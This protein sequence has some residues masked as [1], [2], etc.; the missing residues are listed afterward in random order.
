MY[1]HIALQ[2][3]VIWLLGMY[4]WIGDPLY[5][6]CLTRLCFYSF[7]NG[8]LVC[9]LV[10]DLRSTLYFQCSRLCFL[11]AFVCNIYDGNWH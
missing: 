1:Y 8:F 10:V 5:F 9:I 3:L 11:P 7:C 4:L 2:V 6:Q